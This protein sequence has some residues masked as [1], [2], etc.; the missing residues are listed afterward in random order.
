MRCLFFLMFRNLGPES[1]NR[2]SWWFTILLIERTNYYFE[3]CIVNRQP[4][5]LVILC[6]CR[7]KTGSN[8]LFAGA[9]SNGNGIYNV[10]FWATAQGDGGSS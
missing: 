2:Y 7:R 3:I 4:L 5:P 6:S 10:C 8:Q 1:G 9:C